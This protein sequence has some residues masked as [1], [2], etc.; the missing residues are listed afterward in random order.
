MNQRSSV[1]QLAARRFV[2]VGIVGVTMAAGLLIPFPIGGRAWTEIFNLAHAPSFM[3][4][5]LVI[6]GVCDPVSI[7]LSTKFQTIVRITPARAACGC[8]IMVSAGA[9]AELLQSLLGRSASLGDALANAI[10]ATAA[11]LWITS[12]SGSRRWRLTARCGSVILLLCGIWN[13]IAGLIDLRSQIRQ[14]PV[15][16]SLERARELSI[17]GGTNATTSR[18]ND[19]SADGESSLKVALRPAKYSGAVLMWP[20]ADWQGYERLHIDL[21]NP[22]SVPLDV[23]VK[24]S[25]ARHERSDFDPIDRFERTISVS[26]GQQSVFEVS[27]AEIQAAPAGREMDL[28]QI[29]RIEL[30]VVDNRTSAILFIDNVRLTGRRHEPRKANG[31]GSFVNKLPD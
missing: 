26:P 21:M 4:L 9:V 1:R 19:W 12:H 18:S 13:P 22:G 7:G 15:L 5:T 23:T 20:V 6:A 11:F 10:G 27:L 3:L 16:S 30:F 2:L 14:F 28:S 17:W 24:I 8:I 25:D 31:L 29:A